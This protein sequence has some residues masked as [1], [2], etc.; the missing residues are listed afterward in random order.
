MRMPPPLTLGGDLEERNYK[1]GKF[2]F[3][4]LTTITLYHDYIC[5]W[6]YTGFF[7][8]LK[9]MKQ[10]GVNFDWRG[11]ELIPPSMDY[12]PAAPKPVDPNAPPPPPPKPSRFDLFAEAE[13]FVPPKPRP[14]FVRSHRALLGQ[15]FAWRQGVAATVAYNEAVYRGFWEE[16]VD[17]SNLDLLTELAVRAGLDGTAFEAA[18][19]AE[20][21]VE[22]IVPFDD[23]AY[24]T[25]IR[26]VPLFLFGG[27]ELLTEAPYTSLAAACDNFLFRLERW[28][29]KGLIT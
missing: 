26:H 7:H 13:G 4:S 25:G 20:Q 24:A 5:P 2:A 19:T 17:I 11:T 29:A 14:S 1:S 23:D 8:A 6:C 3:G 27:E 9:L 21:D 12:T 28:K 10:Y 16:Q 15:E 22:N 18:V